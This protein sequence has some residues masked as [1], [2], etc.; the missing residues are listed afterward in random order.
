MRDELEQL[1]REAGDLVLS[2]Q[3]EN[4]NVTAKEG[5]AN[6]V[7]KYDVAVQNLI[8]KRLAEL[9]PDAKFVGEEEEAR[10]DIHRGAAFVVDP[11]DGTTNFIKGCNASAI[12]IAMLEDGRPVIGAIYDPYRDELF[13]AEKGRGA[14]LNN[15]PVHA[16]DTDLSHSLVCM[17]TAPYYPELLPATMKLTEN[18]LKNGMDL[19]RSG[20][21]VIDLCQVA[22][23]SAGLMFELRLSPWDH[24]AAGFIAQEAGAVISQIDGSPAVYDRPCSILCGTKAARADFFR[25][26]LDKLAENC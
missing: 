2:V 25:L 10:A 4:K 5:T 21:A 16:A 17:G 11:I 13:Y 8:R 19:R 12:S 22:R 1:L 18:L 6:F 26:G 24:A 20:S 23:G 14:E 7:T 15:E 3:D 9:R